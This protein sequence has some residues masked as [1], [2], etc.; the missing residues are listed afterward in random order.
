MPK[1]AIGLTDDLI[2]QKITID[3]FINLC[4]A[5]QSQITDFTE[6]PKYHFIPR[7]QTTIDAFY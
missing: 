5:C 1:E 6:K 3:Q 7:G 4:G 2:R